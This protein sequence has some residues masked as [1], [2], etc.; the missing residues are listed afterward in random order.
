MP[1]DP[2]FLIG[3]G[4]HAL[5]LLDSLLAGGAARDQI[6]LLDRDATQVGKTVLGGPV[7][8]YDLRRLQG[9][10]VHICIGNNQVRSRA[11]AELTRAGSILQTLIDP[12]AIVS[13]SSSI[14]SG[15]FVA[16]GAIIAAN[17]II[18]Q[19]C[20]VNHGAIVDHECHLG[21]FVHVAPGATL[22]GAVFVGT[23][24]LIGA[25]ANLLPGVSVGAETI[26]GA[27]AVLLSDATDRAVYVGVPA[28]KT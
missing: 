10:R 7:E 3:S 24:S 12:R 6:I 2:L 27:G 20:I 17:A 4:G 14:G 19:C 26:I 25:G 1:T 28:R 13:A 9:A 16:A 22:A 23:Q 15:S 8:P 21:D 18:G 5:V 11:H